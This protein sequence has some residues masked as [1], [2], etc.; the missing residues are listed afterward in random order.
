MPYVS[1]FTHDIFISYASVDNEPEDVRWVTCFK[2]DL[3]L[4]LRK[5]LGEDIKIFFDQADLQAFHE[6]QTLIDNAKKSAVFPTEV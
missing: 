3:E 5:R 2:N 6:L 4:A 1:G